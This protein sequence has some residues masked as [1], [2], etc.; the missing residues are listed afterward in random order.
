[1]VSFERRNRTLIE[2][3]RTMLIYAKA[4]LFLWAEAVATACYTQNRSVIRLR[5]DKTPYELLHDKPPDLSFFHVFGALCY[6][7]NNSENLGKLQP[8]ADIGIF[9]DYAPTKKSFQIYNRRTRRIIETIHVDYDELTAMA[10]KHSSSGPV[11]HEMT[12]A[13]ISSGLMPN[14]PPSTPFVRPSR[15]DWDILFQ[16]MF[17]ELLT[18]PPSV[19]YPA[20]EVVALIHEVVAPI[21]AASTGSPSS[22]NV[23]QDVPSLSHYQT[24]PDTQPPIIPNDVEEDNHD[25][26]IAHMGNDPLLWY[27]NSRN[28][29]NHVYKLKKALYGL[30]Q[31]PRAW[32][33][34]LSSF[35][36]SQDFSK[37]VCGPT[38]TSSRS[39]MLLKEQDPL[40]EKHRVN[41]KPI[42][43]AILNNDYYKRFV[44]QSD[45]YSEHAYW[46]ATS[47]PAL[48]P[49]HSSTTVIVEVPK[50]LPK[51]SMV[52]TSLK[53]L[54]RY[55][56]GF[57]QVVKERT[58]ATAI[59]EGTWGF[60]HTKACFRDEIIPFIKE[61][62]DIFNNFN[63]YLVEELADVQKVFYQMEQA[64][65]QH[66]LESRTF[67]V[68]MNQVLSENERLLA[69]AIDNDIVKTVVN[70]S[71]N[72][73]G[74]NLFELS[75]LRAQSQAKDTVIVKLKEKIN[76]LNGNVEDSTVKMEME[77]IETL[78]I[79]LEHR[80]QGL[81]IAALKN[82]LRKLKGKALDNKD[83][84]THSVVP[85]VSN[86]NME[87]I[88][89]K[90]LNKRT[91][92][93]SYIKHT[94]EEALVLRDIVEHVNANYPQDPLLESAF[95]GSQPSGNTK[96]DRILQTPSSNSKNK[97][98]AHPRNVKS[99]LNKRNGT[100][101]VTGSASV[102]KSKKQDD[103]DYVCVNRNACPLTRITSTNEVPPRKPIVLDSESPKP[104]VKLVYSRKPRKNKNTE[105]VSKTKVVQNVLELIR[106]AKIMGFGGLSDL[107]NVTIFKGFIT[108]SGPALHEMT[109]VSLSSGLVPN[110][111]PST[112]FVP[113]TRSDW[114]L[115]FQPMFDESPNVDVHA[116]EVIAP[117]P[118]AVAP[119]HA[120]ST[121]S[122]SSTTVDQDAPS[123]SNSHTTPETP[124]PIF[125]H[126]VE[127]D[128]HDIEVA[129]MAND[130]YFGIPIP[131][132]SSDQS[133]SDVIHKIVHPD[134]QVSEHNSKWTKDHPLE[135]IIGELDRPVSTRLQ[136]HEQ[137][138]FCY[139]DAFLTAVEPKTYKDALTQ[140][141]W[142][143]AMQEELNEFERLEVWELVPRPD[144]VMVIT[145]K[146]IYKVKL[147]ELG[148]I[149]KNKARLVARGYRQEEGIDFE[150][151]FAPVA[152]LE[153][154]RIF[155]AFAAH[156]NMVVYQMDVKTAFLNGNLREEVYVSQPDGFVDKD[157][158]NHVYKLKKAL[159]GLKQAPRAW[160]DMLSSFLISQDFSKGS[161]DP[162]LF[163]RRD[164]KELL[165][166]Q[167]YVDDII[168]AASTPE[169]CDLFS[170]IMCSK[171]KMSMMGKISFFLGLQI[172]QSPRGIF[173]NQSKYALES[174]NKYG[175][176]SCDPVDTPM[177]EK[178][179]LD[180]DKLGKAVDP[181]HYRGMIGTLLYLTTSRPDLQFVICMCA[182]YQARPTK[183]HLNAVKRIFRY[184]K[185]TVH[186]GLWYPK[187]SSI[188]LT[189]FADADH[190][191]CQDTRRSTS[192]SMQLLGDRL[193]SWSS[194][195]QKS[196]AISSTEA[197]YIALSGCCAQILWM[198]SQLTDYGFGFNK[199]P[200]M[201]ENGVTELYFVNTEYQL[202]DIF[203]KALGRNR[204]EFLINK[205]G[206]RSF[207]P[208][209]LKQLA[210]EIYGQERIRLLQL[211]ERKKVNEELRKFRLWEI[212][213]VRRPT[214]PTKEPY[215]SIIYVSSFR[216]NSFT[217]KMEILLEPTSNKLM[218]EH[219][220]FDESNANVLE[221]F[222]T[223][224]GNPVKEILLK[225]NLPDHRILKDG[226]EVK[227]FQRS[228]R[229]SDTER[230]SRSDKV[231]KLK[232]FK[233]DATLKLFKS[234][235][236]ERFP[237]MSSDNASFVVTYTSISSDLNGPSWGIPLMNVDELLE[238][239]PYEEYVPV[240]VP[241]PEHPE[242]HVPSDDD[243]QVEDQPY[244]NDA[245]LTAESPGY[246]ANSES[247]E[248][249]SIDY[250][251]EPE[252]DDDADPKEDSS[253]EHEL[254]DDEED[255]NEEHEPEDEDTKEEGPFEGSNETEP[256]EE[257]KTDVTPP[258]L[259]HHGA[260]I[261]VR[262][263]TPMAA[264]TLALIDAFVAGSPLFP[265]TPTSPAYDQAP[266][267]HRAA[268]IS[269]SSAAGARP[270]KG[271]YDFV[272][273]VEAGQGLIRSPGHDARTI[274]RA[275]D[276]A[277]Y[278]GYVRA[279]QASEHRMMTS[280]KEFNLRVSYQAHVCKQGSE[281][282]Y[283]QLHDAQTDRRDIILKI[284]VV[285]GQRTAYETELHEVRQAY[286]SSKAQNRALLARLK[287]LE[288]HM[289][290]MEWQCQRVEDHAV[291]QMM[292]T[293]VLEAR[294]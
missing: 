77:E 157:N 113:P 260:M 248:E 23:D 76:S 121:G 65:E 262:P 217:M 211:L 22:T 272:D 122:P 55:L 11:L 271:Q 99:S 282:F 292:R 231:L 31:A 60:E 119:E 101:K 253:E 227:E 166:V 38:L 4:P 27:P 57:D 176:D 143:E 247:M 278:V 56:T 32:Y 125:S 130:P 210:D 70:L 229:H 40:F 15:I 66:R 216:V 44:R 74:E 193:V 225:L 221:R 188:A 182:R 29:P 28:N 43:Y 285:R 215:D 54:K 180:E 142:I 208:E 73:C 61:L 72:A 184:L 91:A 7:T 112:P 47:V 196:A 84:V 204:I 24:T 163:I 155:L 94:R 128:N 126:D 194:K 232:N 258:P 105:S 178:S 30:K 108:S 269:E 257:D 116:P 103:S 288:T 244:A 220:E 243:M 85:K 201:F 148:G 289:S 276:R 175:F 185:G 117:I 266:L 222:Y 86:D 71:V 12:P 6:S 206:M 46:K 255:P 250:P 88:T 5:H 159:Y 96:N 17:D 191:G 140:A 209:T 95:S 280:I 177:V 263:Q 264:S 110:P 275:T 241:E 146:W 198:R 173:I 144:K 187:D 62:K 50:E 233:K 37:G 200:I 114:D 16:P 82:E 273:T 281:D 287:T 284:D 42:N 270:P 152:R 246:I 197:E 154:I 63:Q 100:V 92:H 149:L 190:A 230:L 26:E 1:M 35:L 179:K 93:S 167:I 181:S 13:T 277:E 242:Y 156:M 151:S 133:S 39:K 120:V 19:D 291:R 51:V 69:Q 20:S 98:E 183:K 78:N 68:K 162:T 79:E 81:V 14:P 286:L 107:G 153:A 279:L 165:L 203:T 226:G 240:Y 170:K 294:A 212:G 145:L 171:F 236:Q 34:M 129:H 293:L 97:V 235:N 223:S 195:R 238:M 111:S 202:A 251:D 265:L 172:S 245:S 160:Y 274:A 261:S 9:I 256:F 207:T 135:N 218:V 205:L 48:D 8:K 199:I 106:V 64:V 228:F 267:G 127:E 124:T 239:D 268:M 168:F 87:P 36:I 224:A 58:T 290:R 33:D 25:I 83:N 10:S 164:G 59:T 52:N 89:P 2:A 141:C 234:T 18:P 3:A 115:L 49:S 137:A 161:V 109:P 45:L 134:H 41:T 75:E 219:A 214:L 138:L 169:L 90:L 174:L 150:E 123:P 252:E 213:N 192:G 254:D 189:T 249:D 186:R 139:Y 132:V 102:Q 237:V 283:T 131:E 147:D 136:L 53:E 21:P 104:V 158:P 118:D 259:G 80:E 67:E